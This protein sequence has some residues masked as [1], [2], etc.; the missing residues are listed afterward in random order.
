MNSASSLRTEDLKG[1]LNKLNGLH[2]A[3]SARNDPQIT[4]TIADMNAITMVL[5]A[6][7]KAGDISAAVDDGV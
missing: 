5:A 1:R 3:Q 2:S 6:R 4:H 7:F